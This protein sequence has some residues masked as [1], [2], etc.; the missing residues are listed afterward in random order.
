LLAAAKSAVAHQN[1]AAEAKRSRKLAAAEC[2]AGLMKLVV[3]ITKESEN[4]L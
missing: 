4:R 1:I 3:P 2:D